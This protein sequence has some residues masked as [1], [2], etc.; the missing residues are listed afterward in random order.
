MRGLAWRET[1]YYTPK[2]LESQ[3]E[4]IAHASSKNA[5]S[6]FSTLLLK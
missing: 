3:T 6:I 1:V 4:I 2:K 5:V